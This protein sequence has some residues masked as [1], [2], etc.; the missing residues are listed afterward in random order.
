LLAF[1]C[2]AEREANL[3]AGNIAELTSDERIQLLG[4]RFYANRDLSL[5]PCLVVVGILGGNYAYAVSASNFGQLNDRSIEFLAPVSWDMKEDIR[6]S[7]GTAVS[8]RFVHGLNG[9]RVTRLDLKGGYLQELAWDVSEC[10][11]LDAHDIGASPDPGC[12]PSLLRGDLDA[13]RSHP[14]IASPFGGD[15][16]LQWVIEIEFPAKGVGDGTGDLLGGLADTESLTACLFGALGGC[17]PHCAAAPAA[18]N[19][20]AGVLKLI[21]RHKVSL[22]LLVLGPTKCLA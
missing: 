7:S 16:T 11:H 5:F 20:E 13:D 19:D 15:H 1:L 17:S 8:E 4:I 6:A 2:S 9:D 3:S 10:A 22:S 12:A 18:A 14:T 21:A